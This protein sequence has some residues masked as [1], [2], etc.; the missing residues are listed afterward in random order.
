MQINPAERTQFTYARIAGFLYLFLIV[1]YMGGALTLANIAAPGDF[2]ETARS[3]AASG[4]LYSLALSSQ[5]VTS[6]GTILLAFALF[7]TLKPV[8]RDLAQMA[9]YWRLGDAFIGGAG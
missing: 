7:Q 3:I 5:L 4:R 2:A 8:H 6:V 9:L 1:T